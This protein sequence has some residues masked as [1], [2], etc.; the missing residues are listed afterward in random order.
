MYTN[1]DKRTNSLNGGV[2]YPVDCIH[3]LRSRPFTFGAR[4]CNKWTAGRVILCGDAAH[5]LP[6]CMYL[7]STNMRCTDETSWWAGYCIRVQRRVRHCMETCSCLPSWFQRKLRGSF[8]WLVSRTQ[9]AAGSVTCD[10]NRQWESHNCSKPGENLSKRLDPL[11]HATCSQSEAQARIG[12]SCERYGTV[13]ILLWYGIST[14]LCRWILS[15]TSLLSLSLSPYER[16][17]PSCTVH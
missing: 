14:R 9:T 7:T 3:V 11:A 6:P 4:S 5:V 8:Q 15:A 16:R 10:Y 2:H 13:Q 12:S 17:H 1:A